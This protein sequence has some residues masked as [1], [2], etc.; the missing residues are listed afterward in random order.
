MSEMFLYTV[1]PRK[2]II[3]LSGSTKVIRTSKSVYLTKEDV[4]LCLKSAIV[5]R[6]FANE[7]INE[8]V[9]ID[10]VERVHRE[11]YISPEDWKKF[12]INQKAAAQGT[13]VVN[14]NPENNNPIED[15]VVDE[16]VDPVKENEEEKECELDAPTNNESE[17]S[18]DSSVKEENE[19]DTVITENNDTVV[20][21]EESQN[22][23]DTN[24]ESDDDE[25][26]EKV[27]SEEE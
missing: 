9:T 15:E 27:N 12:E 22:V 10:D 14:E 26:I 21:D 18:E 23:D 7:G 24:V 5:Y 2:V 8:R 16:T 13:V 6:R 17:H 4:F 19:E 3:G 1:K 11:N 20:A 25:E